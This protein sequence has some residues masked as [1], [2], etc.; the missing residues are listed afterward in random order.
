M[1]SS[2]CDRVM[3]MYLGK[4]VEI[5]PVEQIYAAPRHPYTRALLAAVPSM[6]PARRVAHLVFSDDP[7]NP[8]NP[9]SGCRFRERFPHAHAVCESRAPELL[10]LPEVDHQ[11]ACHMLAPG[12]GHPEAP[13]ATADQA[14][15]EAAA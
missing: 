12:S 9:L 8:I 5:G 4:V 3:V 13:P 2:T 7:P 10:A 14:L 11:A 15:D 1:W 6:D